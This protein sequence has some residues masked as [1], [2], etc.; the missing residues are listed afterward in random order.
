MRRF[1]AALVAAVV[2][3]GC[4]KMIPFAHDP[5]RPANPLSDEQTKA[6]VV[7]PAKQITTIAK[8]QN[9]SGVFGWESCNDQGD[10]PFRGRVDVSFDV[11]AGTD[12]N[13]YFEQIAATMI[14]HGWSDGPPP[15]KQPFGRT[16]H[17][18]GVMAI[19]GLSS[20]TVKDGSVELSGE[21]RNMGD[22]G[23]DGGWYDVTDQLR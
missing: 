11:P 20:G 8:L 10:P 13:A 9:V 21:C 15:G 23:H 7:D 12:R 14:G 3:G 2:L 22:H 5:D 1:V 18:G 16:I 17:T 4:S 6:Q 19:I